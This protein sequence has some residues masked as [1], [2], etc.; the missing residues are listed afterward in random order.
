[1]RPALPPAARESSS[2]CHEPFLMSQ[3]LAP[4]TSLM[5]MGATLPRKIEARNE[6]TREMR[7]V[8]L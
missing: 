6:D 4:H 1:V 2:S 3:R 5:S 7:D 8:A